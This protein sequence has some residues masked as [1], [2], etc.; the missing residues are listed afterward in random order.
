MSLS[1]KTKKAL[2]NKADA[3][4][5][6]GKNVTAGQ[7]ARVY[8]RGL[9]AYKTGHRPGTSQHQWAMARVNS[10]LTGGKAATVDKDI[11]KGKKAA[12]KTK[13]KPKAKKTKKA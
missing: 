7:L 4:R 11:M 10:V 9:A 6:K 2:S 3:A 13:A 1:A 5:K 8:K 12:S